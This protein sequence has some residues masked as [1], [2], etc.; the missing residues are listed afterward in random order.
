MFWMMLGDADYAR[1]EY[2]KWR[3]NSATALPR[4]WRVDASSAPHVRNCLH[5]TLLG[6]IVDAAHN[7]PNILLPINDRFICVPP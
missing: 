5:Y 6:L 1:A 7:R 4:I 2:W 3:P